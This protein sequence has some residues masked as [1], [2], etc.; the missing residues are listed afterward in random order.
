MK[1]VPHSLL[2]HALEFAVDVGVADTD[3]SFQLD[4]LTKDAFRLEAHSDGGGSLKIAA[5]RLHDEFEHAAEEGVLEVVSAE[6]LDE[7][8]V[9]LRL[10]REGARDASIQV[11]L[12]VFRQLHHPNRSV[13]RADGVN[14]WRSS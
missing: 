5:L 2:A 12:R 6:V 13:V 4:D 3:A 11:H 8:F 7:L 14:E 9:S 1:Y 10:F